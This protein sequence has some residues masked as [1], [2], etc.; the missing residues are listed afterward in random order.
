MRHLTFSFTNVMTQLAG[1]ETLS[2]EYLIQSTPIALP[3]GLRNAA[4][5]VGHLVAQ[6]T[7]PSPTNDEFVGMIEYFMESFHDPLTLTLAGGAIAPSRECFMVGTLEGYIESIH[8]GGATPPNDLNNEVEGDAGA[9]P[10][11]RV[12]QLMMRHRE[13]ED[14]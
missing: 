13:I 2:L 4:E 5:T 8:E 9:P 6:H 1:G 14:A 12:E 3:F 7:P 11:L 10:C